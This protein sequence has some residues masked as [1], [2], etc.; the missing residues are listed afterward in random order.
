MRKYVIGTSKL[1]IHPTGM[2]TFKKEKD[3]DILFCLQCRVKTKFYFVVDFE[4]ISLTL[5]QVLHH[6]IGKLS[7]PL[8]LLHYIFYLLSSW[9]LLVQY[10]VIFAPT[11]NPEQIILE[12]KIYESSENKQTFS[13]ILRPGANPIYN[14]LSLW[15][16]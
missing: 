14:N 8:L 11:F 13:T 1:K 3:C 5:L 6:K 4:A 7:I 9:S 10:Q 12:R 15:L 2:A 16:V